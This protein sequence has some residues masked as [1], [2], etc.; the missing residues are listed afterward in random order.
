MVAVFCG[1]KSGVYVLTDY[2][3]GEDDGHEHCDKEHVCE[4]QF[5]VKCSKDYL[6]SSKWF[7]EIKGASTLKHSY[8]LYYASRKRVVG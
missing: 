1:K 7:D 6:L 5:L 4:D 2:K 3:D 8:F